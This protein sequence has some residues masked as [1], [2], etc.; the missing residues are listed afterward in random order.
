MDRNPTYTCNSKNSISIKIRMVMINTHRSERTV[1]RIYMTKILTTVLSVQNL[2]KNNLLRVLS[3][4]HQNEK[5][6]IKKRHTGA[7]CVGASFASLAARR[8]L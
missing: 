6:N 1:F 4:N 8:A 5:L 7:G 2:V 3:F